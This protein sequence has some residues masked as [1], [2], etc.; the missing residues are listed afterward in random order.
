VYV[1]SQIACVCVTLLTLDACRA[2]QGQVY[3]SDTDLPLI[4]EQCKSVNQVRRMRLCLRCVVS[5]CVGVLV[6]WA[7]VR[8]SNTTCTGTAAYRHVDAESGVLFA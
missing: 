3:S 4:L 6:Q 1:L 5:M 2:P 7:C 8:V